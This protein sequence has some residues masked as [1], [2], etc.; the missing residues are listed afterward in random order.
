MGKNDLTKE[1]LER[2]MDSY[3]AMEDEMLDGQRRTMCE[4]AL[5]ALAYRNKEKI[6]PVA[7]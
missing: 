6:Y 4:L 7:D 1:M 5:E 2:W 3:G